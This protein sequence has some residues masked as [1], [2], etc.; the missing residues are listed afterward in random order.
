M[1]LP[2][3]RHRGPRSRE[4]SHLHD[5]DRPTITR[6]AE[7]SR[8]DDVVRII[9][10]SLMVR[11]GSVIDESVADERARN[12]AQCLDGVGVGR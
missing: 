2:T 8:L 6:R 7:Q 4:V 5:L 10:E 9:R 3:D 11:A 1:M 12:I